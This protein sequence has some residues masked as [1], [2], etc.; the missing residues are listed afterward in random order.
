MASTIFLNLL[1]HILEKKKKITL[2]EAELSEKLLSKLKICI[3]NFLEK[4]LDSESSYNF[5]FSILGKQELC[6]LLT[7]MRNKLR[8]LINNI[9]DFYKHD[10]FKN[11]AIQ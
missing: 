6:T 8:T 11:T 2:S 9:S 7:S 4:L 3:R 10:F 1:L 5:F